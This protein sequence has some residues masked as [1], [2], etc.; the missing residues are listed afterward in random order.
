MENGSMDEFEAIFA[1]TKANLLLI[2]KGI[3]NGNL[4]GRDADDLHSFHCDI[5]TVHDEHKQMGEDYEVLFRQRPSPVYDDVF[6]LVESIETSI[7]NKRQDR[8]YAK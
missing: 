7:V 4:D 1:G 2:C 8:E 6:P 3:G 5:T